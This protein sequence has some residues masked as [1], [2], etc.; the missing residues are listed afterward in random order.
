MTFQ[1]S[2]Q[3][4]ELL[5]ETTAFQRDLLVAIA[6]QDAPKGTAIMHAVAIA[7]GKDIHHGRLYPNLD[8]L[9][10]MGLVH[11]GSKDQRTNEYTLTPAG[12]REL[13]AQLDWARQ[14]LAGYL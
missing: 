10:E 1:E 9:E 6:G 4:P 7:Y 5:E 13:R 3:K 14:G 12:Q 11:I 8:A 2:Q